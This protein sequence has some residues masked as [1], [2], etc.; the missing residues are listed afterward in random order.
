MSDTQ[1]PSLTTLTSDQVLAMEVDGTAMWFIKNTADGSE[2]TGPYT[3]E[4]LRDYVLAHQEFS[5]DFV[6]NKVGTDEWTTIV[7]LSEF[8]RK[9][10]L[11]SMAAINT[12]ATFYLLDN[13]HKI[14][15][16]SET[17]INEKLK[18]KELIY[19]DFISV[20][21]GFNWLKVFELPQFD[22]RTA[23]LAEALPLSPTEEVFK[24][25]KLQGLKNIQDNQISKDILALVAFASK[26]K[27]EVMP[28]APMEEKSHWWKSHKKAIYA[29]LSLMVFAS[30]SWKYFNK[31]STEQAQETEN[32]E[33]MFAQQPIRAQGAPVRA[34]QMPARAPANENINHPMQ[35]NHYNN[36]ANNVPVPIED[37]QINYDEPPPADAPDPVEPPP[38]VEAAQLNPPEEP[39]QIAEVP[40]P[41]P[42]VER[43]PANDPAAPP[44]PAPKE[45]EIFNQEA[46][47]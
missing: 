47:N 35:L 34:H 21:K 15:P 17:E 4:N 8:K 24:I 30:V 31:P 19:S 11:V 39:Q 37:A 13:G 6:A 25:S 41:M 33:T 46:Q 28:D 3:E 23:S 36:Q 32:F 5:A 1:I 43:E 40:E 27:N 29:S 16:F 14:G 9:P 12:N 26:R 38:P 18:S 20:D 2:K 7:E 44:G 22:G 42:E 10:Q 45:E